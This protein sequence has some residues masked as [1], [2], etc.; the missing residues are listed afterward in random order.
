VTLAYITE[1]VRHTRRE[2]RAALDFAELF[3]CA[4]LLVLSQ[5][6]IRNVFLCFVPLVFVLRR[7]CGRAQAL[8][9]PS[10]VAVLA[11][12][13][14]LLS[15]GFHYV[16][17]SPYAQLS[18]IPSAFARDLAPNA[19]PEQAARF[20][21][22]AGV[23]GKVMGEIAWGGYLIWQ[24]WPGSTVLADTRQNFTPELRELVFATFD[25]QRRPK[26]MEIA[27]T[28]FG[29]DIAVFKAPTFPLHL[30][31]P[32]WELL[33]KAGFE[34]V[35]QRTAGPRAER[36]RQQIAA[37]LRGLGARLSEPI[38]RMQLTDAAVA[39]GAR[40][41]LSDAFT[42]ERARA[43]EED[44]ASDDRARQLRGRRVRGYLRYVTGAYA[45]ARA[46]LEV[47]AQLDAADATLRYRLSACHFVLGDLAAARSTLLALAPADLARLRDHER[48]AAL[49]LRRELLRAGTAR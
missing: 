33:Y 31:A 4:G 10:G 7:S 23:E 45:A 2:G 5:L 43:A 35:H 48:G 24:L 3:L 42:A 19:F 36:N 39:E 13:L 1:R 38:D 29:I 9:V 16:V 34:E 30:P 40:R 12:T 49:A 25:P 46:D 22:Q 44:L 27:A 18:R 28:R 14:A 17:V 37:Y 6:A 8:T 11:A 41:Y 20:L 21:R 32:G 15:V 26:A 47:A